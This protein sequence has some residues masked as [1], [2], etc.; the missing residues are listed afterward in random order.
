MFALNKSDLTT[1]WSFPTDSRINQ[2]LAVDQNDD[3]YF[4]TEAGTLYS[5]D[6]NGNLN[7]KIE[8]GVLSQISPVLT[9]N[10]VIWGYGNKVVGILP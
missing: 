1:K 3:V 4:S 10:G 5:V 9:E 2:Q 6:E 7:W 8:S